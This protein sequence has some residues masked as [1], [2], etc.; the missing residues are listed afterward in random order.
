MKA[1]NIRQAHVAKLVQT[2]RIASQEALKNLLEQQ[3][4]VVGQATLSRDLRELGIVKR[5]DERGYFFVLTDSAPLS[6]GLHGPQKMAPGTVTSL[7]A[8]GS[9]VVLK[10]R[11]GYASMVATQ[12][13][14]R[15]LAEVAGT[16]AG[17]DT[18]LVVL[19]PG[20]DVA[21]LKQSLGGFI[22]DITAFND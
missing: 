2:G 7:E 16:L 1:K 14:A 19:R 8:G 15:N 20:F 12:I 10:T 6:D 3:G 22:M 13:D 17:D 5:H 18:L 11:P 21:A 4:I 9:L